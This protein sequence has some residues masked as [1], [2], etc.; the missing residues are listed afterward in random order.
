MCHVYLVDILY[1]E[2]SVKEHL[3]LIGKVFMIQTDA[4]F[5]FSTLRDKGLA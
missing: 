3:E 5:V 4:V 2:L 1:D